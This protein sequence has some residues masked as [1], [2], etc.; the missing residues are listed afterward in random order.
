MSLCNLDLSKIAMPVQCHCPDSVQFCV[1]Q[2]YIVI[3]STSDLPMYNIPY[4]SYANTSCNRT[5]HL[6]C[7]ILEGMAWKTYHRTASI[8][9]AKGVY[10]YSLSP[11]HQ[12]SCTYLVTLYSTAVLL[13][14][15]QTQLWTTGTM[16]HIFNR[17]KQ[18]SCQELK[19]KTQHTAV[20]QISSCMVT[21][22]VNVGTVILVHDV[23]HSSKYWHCMTKY[24]EP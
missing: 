24:P 5:G 17:F 4:Y 3:C 16:H 13:S 21:L 9:E 2:C 14:P 19:D 1:T 7:A 6:L 8:D 15:S 10:V 11:I 23:K 22:V 20:L 12:V 18:I